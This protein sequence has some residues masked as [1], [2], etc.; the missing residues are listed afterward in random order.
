LLILLAI[1]SGYVFKDQFIGLGSNYFQ[2]SLRDLG[3]LNDA[4]F[5][6]SYIKLIPFIYTLIVLG[7]AYLLSS[8]KHLDFMNIYAQKLFIYNMFNFLSHKWYFNLLQ[9]TYISQK[10]LN[11]GYETF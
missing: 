1:F 7:S 2:I 10:L 11:A 6:P 5:L 9:N 4:E 3:S 8:E